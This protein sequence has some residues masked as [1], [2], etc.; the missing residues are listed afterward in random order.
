MFVSA[1][2]SIGVERRPAEGGDGLERSDERKRI[3]EGSAGGS[4]KHRGRAD[5]ENGEL[6]KGQTAVDGRRNSYLLVL[7]QHTRSV[8]NI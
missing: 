1:G 4:A 8:E 7:V 3:A 6:P 5:A 2:K